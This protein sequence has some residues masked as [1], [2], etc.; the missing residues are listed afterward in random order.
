MKESAL[1]RLQQELR[2]SLHN[3]RRDDGPAVVDMRKSLFRGLCTCKPETLLFMEVADL[4]AIISLH[5]S[6]A[7][8]P[9]DAVALRTRDGN[10]LKEFLLDLRSRKALPLAEDAPG[11]MTELLAALL[12]SAEG[13]E[14]YRRCALLIH[15]AQKERDLKRLL[16]GG[17]NQPEEQPA[18]AALAAGDEEV[19]PVRS[20]ADE[21]LFDEPEH[22]GDHE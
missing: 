14:T 20:D 11:P 2:E 7:L 5:F 6:S 15:W 13:L 12:E 9:K 21:T 22:G 17:K 16:A 4:A 19:E 10:M 18:N 1:E 8:K 3:Y